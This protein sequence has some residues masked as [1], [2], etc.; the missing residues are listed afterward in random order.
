MK[1]YKI[2]LA[3]AS[4]ALASLA[5]P[6]CNE[7]EVV[8]PL[9]IPVATLKANTTIADFKTKYWKTDDN[10]YTEVGTTASGE[11]TVIA[12]RVIANDKSGNIY[13]NVVIQDSTAAV[14]IAVSMKNMYLK[15]HIGEEVI[16]DLTGLYAGKYSGL[17]QIG[18]A[19]T[20]TSGSTST[21][22]IG[23]MAEET[24]NAHAQFN[25]LPQ[26]DSVRVIE[27]TIEE[28]LANQTNPEFLIKYQSQLIEL[29]GVSFKG[30]GELLW[31]ERGTSHN[32]RYLYN[33]SGR[34]IAVDNS[35]MSDF[36]DKVLPVGHGDVVAIA[37]YFR[38]AFQ[39]VFRSNDDC[40]DF[41]GDSYAPVPLVSAGNGS[42]ETPF[43]V[44]AVVNGDASGTGWVTGYIVGWVDGMSL[45]SGAR[46]TT[47]ASS[48]SNILLA[49]KPDETAVENCI[50]VQLSGTVRSALNLK[51]H[52]D[53]LGKEVSIKGSFEKYF[54]AAG[55]KSPTAY[56]WGP[57]G[58]ESGTPDTPVTGGATFK[59]VTAVTSG[60][61]YL[62]VAGGKAAQLNT[63]DHGYLQVA[64]VTDNNGVI[65]A[66]AAN[67]FTFTSVSGGYT[68][69]MS[70][71]NYLLQTGTYNSYNF[72]AAP[73]EGNIFTVEPQ[74]DGS[75][76]I[77]CVSVGKYLQYSQQYNSY[78]SYSDARGTMPFL[79]E[80]VD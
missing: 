60:K 1:R 24:F 17:F 77:T 13:Q 79:Y 62:I 59:K 66:D 26:P 4:L 47:P 39:L 43:N 70:N 8:A 72:S 31:A 23:K 15:C 54:G 50:P 44:G 12:G 16:I 42:A 20:Y 19:D 30:G 71:G 3:A 21:P 53:N 35:G 61:Q 36:N 37:S 25:G 6:S 18:K 48:A 28:M 40:I 46:F 78:G 33:Q 67:A 74:S 11:H 51:D 7:D 38:S 41:G 9:D 32:T 58:D 68:I 10:Y 45:D 49:S 27:M 63:A 76:K 56:S 73:T 34:K 55:L 57:K 22:Q 65:S 2:M 80:K 64:D 69:M 5:L 75:F 29:K 52:A 14:C